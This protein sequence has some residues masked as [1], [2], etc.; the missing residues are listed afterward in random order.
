MW[1]IICPKTQVPNHKVINQ[2]IYPKKKI[3]LIYVNSEKPDE[4][5]IRKLFPKKKKNLKIQIQI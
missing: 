3:F 5:I 1:I 2:N 4:K